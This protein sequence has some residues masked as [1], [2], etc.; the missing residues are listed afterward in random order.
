MEYIKDYDFPIKY[1]SGKANVVA[2]ALSR[3]SGSLAS[4]KVTCIFQQF[5][6]LGVDLQPLRNGVMLANMSVS[7]PSFIQKI[8]NNQLQDPE[9]AKILEHIAKRPDFCIVDGILYYRDRLYVPNIEDLRNDTMAEAHNTKYSMHLGS[10]KMYQNLKGRFWW[11]N[12]KRE[13]VAFVSRCMTCQLVKAEHQKPPGLLQPLEIPKWKWEHI[14]MDFI[15]GLPRTRKG[16][17]TI[18]VIVDR[19]TESAHFIAMKIGE[20]M[21][22]LPLAE[23]SVNE[24]V[25]RHGQPVSITSDRE[26]RFISRFWK[27][28]HES[29]GIKLQFSTAYHP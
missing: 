29:M 19:L 27:T 14:I 8:K 2:D 21:H 26:S 10:T 15:L 20:K 18:W 4:L 24:I 11:N 1:H 7:E 13:I 5:E 16:N 25:S 6:E 23:L 3:K 9:L 28:L 12:M 22:M 17:N